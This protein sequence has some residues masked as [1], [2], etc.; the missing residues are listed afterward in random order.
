MW[1]CDGVIVLSG[2]EPDSNWVPTLV[3]PDSN[4]L[5][6]SQYAQRDGLSISHFKPGGER[7]L[8]KVQ[9]DQLQHCI[10]TFSMALSCTW[11]IKAK[12]NARHII[13]PGSFM[14]FC[15]KSIDIW[16]CLS[17]SKADCKSLPCCSAAV[18]QCHTGGRG[19]CW[20][21][22]P[23]DKDMRVWGWPGLRW[24]RWTAVCSNQP[25]LSPSF[26]S[27]PLTDQNC[28]QKTVWH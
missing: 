22:I 7:W 23:R 27:S 16:L 15:T 18:L 14:Y 11:L 1:W 26:L 21:E 28:N 12:Y 4:H 17:L 10:L 5:Q 24:S 9:M 3:W 25:T 6:Y 20:R 2:R 13:G 8:S 19:V